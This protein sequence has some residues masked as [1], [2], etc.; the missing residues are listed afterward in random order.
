[1]AVERDLADH[2]CIDLEQGGR[3]TRD[4]G[5]RAVGLREITHFAETIARIEVAQIL[6]QFTHRDFPVYD[7]IEGVVQLAFQNN[8]R[9]VGVFLRFSSAHDLPDLGVWKA[10]EELQ[11]LNG[12]EFFLL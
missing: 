7:D 9:S 3:A 1:M 8:L 6:V 5:R 11:L 2:R 4:D 12:R 10:Q